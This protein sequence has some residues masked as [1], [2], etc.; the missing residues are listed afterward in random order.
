LAAQ[1]VRIGLSTS[2]PQQG[3]AIRAALGITVGGTRL[4][5]SVQ[6]TYNL[7][8][9][10]A[11]PALAEAHEA[12]W[13]VII[14]EGLANGRLTGAHLAEQG[15]DDSVVA[16]V[17]LKTAA[18]VDAVALAAIAAQRWVDVV[19]SGA[20]TVPQLASN[21]AAAQVEVG[22]DQLE[23]LAALAMPP[24]EYWTRRSQMAWR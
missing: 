20:A 19:L 21:L 23:Q 16:E 2:G 24:Q 10:S 17:A 11:G 8:E 14:K 6:A 5:E 13:T 12:G 15:Q 3:E 1:G 9:T 22:P 4:F 7:L 18:S